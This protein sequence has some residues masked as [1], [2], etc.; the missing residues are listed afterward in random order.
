MKVSLY[1]LAASFALGLST[2]SARLGETEEQC[3]ARYGEST[4][5]MP[6]AQYEKRLDV[7]AYGNSPDY[8]GDISD[9]CSQP[10]IRVDKMLQYRLK[11]CSLIVG[12]SRDKAVSIQY[13]FETDAG[14]FYG[15]EGLPAALIEGIL[16]LNV[17]SAVWFFKFDAYDAL[18]EELPFEM[19]GKAPSPAELEQYA[20]ERASRAKGI[21]WSKDG[22]YYAT[23]RRGDGLVSIMESGL[24]PTY[25][26][27]R[28]K[29]ALLEGL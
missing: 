27:D 19:N 6:D 4:P 16:E 2:A 21:F 10:E 5:F 24:R 1:L 28:D 23:F 8:A 3:S 11:N 17:P 29:A 15:D 26:F 13:R 20:S 22:K 18:S 9:Y 12:F 14:K 7:G 25:K